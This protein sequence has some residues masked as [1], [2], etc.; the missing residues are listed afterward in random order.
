MLDTI[1][2]IRARLGTCNQRD[3]DAATLLGIVDCLQTENEKMRGA[4]GRIAN[5]EGHAFSPE[6]EGPD[7]VGVYTVVGPGKPEL[8]KQCTHWMR[9]VAREVLS[10]P[11][12]Q[13]DQNE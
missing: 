5:R 10:T 7:E 4:L 11:P 13:V 1:A 3:V 2:D 12:G 8:T 9:H 6:V